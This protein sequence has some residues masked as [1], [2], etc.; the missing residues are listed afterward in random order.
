MF[1]VNV[2]RIMSPSRSESSPTQKK[3][4]TSHCARKSLREPSSG[5]SQP[6]SP[7]LLC[8]GPSSHTGH[9]HCRASALIIASA[10]TLFQKRVVC[11][12]V[13]ST[14]CTH[15]P[16]SKQPSLTTSADIMQAPPTYQPLGMLQFP[17][18]LILNH[19][20]TGIY[21]CL[22]FVFLFGRYPLRGQRLCPLAQCWVLMPSMMLGPCGGLGLGGV[23]GT[24]ENGCH[25]P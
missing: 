5:G 8:V 14:L 22:L 17:Q 20:V 16:S 25:V 3:T 13:H 11:H 2:N 23:C 12:S 1:S 7:P 10:W 15:F 6:S 18:A 4:H 24:W 21:L 9:S 19:T